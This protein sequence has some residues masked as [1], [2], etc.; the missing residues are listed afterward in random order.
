MAPLS[1][2][3]WAVVTETDEI[4]GVVGPSGFVHAS[5][6]EEATKTVETWRVSLHTDGRVVMNEAEVTIPVDTDIWDWVDERLD[7]VEHGAEA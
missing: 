2:S 7:E 3:D 5:R 4:I 6:I 1:H